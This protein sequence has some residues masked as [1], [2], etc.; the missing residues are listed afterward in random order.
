MHSSWLVEIASVWAY[1]ASA[2]VEEDLPFP[3][4]AVHAFWVQNRTRFN[5]WNALLTAQQRRMES[6]SMGSRIQAW[7]KLKSLL[8]EI[9]LAEPL[10]RVSVAIAARLESRRIDDDTRAILHNV[11][12]THQEVRHRCLKIISQGILS[13]NPEADEL[14]SLRHYL[15]HWTDLLLGYFANHTEAIQYSHNP[16]RVAEF[17]EE[18]SDRMLGEQSKLVWSLLIA[19]CRAWLNKHVAHRPVSPRVNQLI[20]E[21]ALGMIHPNLF[22]SMGLMRSHLVHRIEKGLDQAGETIQRLE[23]GSWEKMSSLVVSPSKPT[24]RRLPA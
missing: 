6:L 4:E 15:E 23:D 9:L 1:H 18:Y 14:N 8:E 7:Q 3:S 21:A 22:D 5:S 13:G 16:T 17:S 11:Y 10:S 19:S 12:T 20:S 24:N 2:R